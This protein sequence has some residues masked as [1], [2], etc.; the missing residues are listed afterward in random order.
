MKTSFQQLLL[1]DDAT[2]V[3]KF[4]AQNEDS[5]N[6]FLALMEH[7]APYARKLLHFYLH[8]RQDEYDALSAA[9]LKTMESLRAGTYREMGAFG[10]W[11][12]RTVYIEGMVVLRRRGKFARSEDMC[13]ALEGQIATDMLVNRF[14]TMHNYKKNRQ[15]MPEDHQKVFDK[16]LIEGMSVQEI[17]DE[18]GVNMGT[19]SS[20]NSRA[21]KFLSRFYG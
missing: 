8:D 3:K 21:K 12:K 17:S 9:Q 20:H 2:L 14:E 7:H 13:L 6:S 15:G 16:Y 4:C 11:Y 1:L 5:D 10:S 18:S 19:V